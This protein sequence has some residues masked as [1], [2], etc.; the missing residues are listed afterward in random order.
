MPRPNEMR[1]TMS[2]ET[3]WVTPPK[4]IRG[5]DHL[6]VQST[7]VA[8][9]TELLPGI[10]NVTDRAGYF[11]FHPWL[12]REFERSFTDR[13]EAAYGRLL[14]QAECLLTHRDSPSSRD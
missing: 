7:S 14:R 11:T 13:S 12:L 1:N 4:P 2:Y 8:L 3:S 6:G 5:L 9:Y 10:T